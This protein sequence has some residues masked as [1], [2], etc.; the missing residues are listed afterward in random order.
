[1]TA[2]DQPVEFGAWATAL[3]AEA[4]SLTASP[5]PFDIY[6]ARRLFK[7][8]HNPKEAALMLLSGQGRSKSRH[9]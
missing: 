2:A 5:P 3:Q 9:R 6:A 4:K 1:M 7:A 8:G